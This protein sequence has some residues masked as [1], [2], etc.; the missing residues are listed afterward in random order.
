MTTAIH[1]KES[2]SSLDLTDLRKVFVQA[3]GL[4]PGT[5]RPAT[6]VAAIIAAQAEAAS[7]N[8][9]QSDEP[10][11]VVDTGDTEDGNQDNDT[12][13]TDDG[14]EPEVVETSEATATVLA[15]EATEPEATVEP[16][17]VAPIKVK[18][19]GTGAHTGSTLLC[20]IVAFTGII[21]T[22]LVLGKEIRF[23]ADSGEP[24]RMK[25]SWQSAGWVVDTNSLPERDAP[26][27]TEMAQMPVR[28]LSL[29]QLRE[30]FAGL[31]GRTTTSTS[32][33]YLLARIK[34]AKNGT[35]PTGTR[36]ARSGEPCKVIPV[37]MAVSTVEAL[38]A[39]WRR[40]GYGNRISFIR[41]ALKAKLVE[42]G[43]DEVA[44]L[45]LR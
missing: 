21:A 23:H 36:R 26:T 7:G 12:Q 11:V 33:T 45:V 8:D 4:G 1:T 15:P 40:C 13:A 10:E 3:T 43:E 42:L 31:T 9:D 34:A 35:L 17:P 20:D 32:R 28:D 44:E 30:L 19:V 24:V 41:D 6:M 37:A 39:A 16:E 29:D 27:P 18:V 14:Q 22:V 2:L 38:D 5:R 25:K